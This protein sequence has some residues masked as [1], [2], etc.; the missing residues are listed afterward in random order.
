MKLIFTLFAACLFSGL[1]SQILFEEYFDNGMPEAVVL[2]NLGELTPDDP[3]LPTGPGNGGNEL[4][5]DNIVISDGPVNVLEATQMEVNVWPVPAKDIVNISLDTEITSA[6]WTL[7]DNTGK[8]VAQNN[9][10]LML[11]QLQIDVSAFASGVYSLQLQ[12]D[13]GQAATRLIID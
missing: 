13:K 10:N 2:E 1:S 11:G 3:D 12:T 4:A 8:V 5:I 6:Q 9:S 7:I